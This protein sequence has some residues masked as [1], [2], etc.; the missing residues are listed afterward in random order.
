MLV[1]AAKVR[2]G[3]TKLSWRRLKSCPSGSK[4]SPRE[5]P[6]PA[7]GGI[8][9]GEGAK[10]IAQ[11]VGSFQSDPPKGW[12]VVRLPITFFLG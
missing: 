5:C 11:A 4:A 7:S 8:F 6:P 2:S 1:F 12:G 9:N 10:Q 3:L